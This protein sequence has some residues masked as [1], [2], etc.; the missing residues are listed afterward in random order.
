MSYEAAMTDP[1]V[2]QTGRWEDVPFQPSAGVPEMRIPSGDPSR[3]TVQFDTGRN[4]VQE[5]P[6]REDMEMSQEP[7]YY[8][9]QP[10]SMRYEPPVREGFN[11]GAAGINPA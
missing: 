7:Q 5:I 9:E 8:Q 2:E 1:P 11:Q 6:G 3:K 4:Q 10:M